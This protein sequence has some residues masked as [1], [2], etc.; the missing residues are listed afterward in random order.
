MSETKNHNQVLE[1]KYFFTGLNIF[2]FL[3]I[4][5]VIVLRFSP[6]YQVGTEPFTG[7]VRHTP[8]GFRGGQSQVCVLQPMQK[9]LNLY[10][11]IL[12]LKEKQQNEYTLCQ[13]WTRLH[14]LV[15]SLWQSP[16]EGAMM[17]WL[18]KIKCSIAEKTQNPNTVHNNVP[19]FY[20][21][22]YSTN[23]WP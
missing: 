21:L 9:I 15:C 11:N 10:R 14:T 16:Q 3:C 20:I 23:S 19:L 8:H 7:R 5:I 4:S 18:R 22:L 13:T 6:F 2:N 12:Y 1:M 17:D